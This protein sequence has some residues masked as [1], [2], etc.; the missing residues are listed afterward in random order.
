MFLIIWL[1]ALVLSRDI[2]LLSLIANPLLM[3]FSL[4]LALSLFLSLTLSLSLLISP[5]LLFSY[6]VSACFSWQWITK[7]FSRFCFELLSLDCNYIDCCYQLQL[8]S[9]LNKNNIKSKLKF[10]TTIKSAKQNNIETLKQ[11]LPFAKYVLT[12]V[13]ITIFCWP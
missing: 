6:Y 11:T 9:F 13:L 5:S 4:L 7:V 8:K 10:Y 12:C 3:F 2:N 1:I